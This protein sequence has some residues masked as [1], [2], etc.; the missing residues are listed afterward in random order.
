MRLIAKRTLLFEDPHNSAGTSN[1][2]HR[3][4]ISRNVAGSGRWRGS[5]TQHGLKRFDRIASCSDIKGEEAI[6]R[7]L[8]GDKSGPKLSLGAL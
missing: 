4:A 5:F 1:R 7:V 3:R 8:S 2:N 6:S